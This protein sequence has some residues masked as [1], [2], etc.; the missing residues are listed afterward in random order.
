ML[1]LGS[2]LLL[3]SSP[4]LPIHARQSPTALCSLPPMLGVLTRLSCVVCTQASFSHSPSY[5]L[6]GRSH[7]VA[8]LAGSSNVLDGRTWINLL[9]GRTYWI[10]QATAGLSVDKAALSM[11]ILHLE[12]ALE[13][14]LGLPID[15]VVWVAACI[16][17]IS[18]YFLGSRC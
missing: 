11:I 4:T 16:I 7:L 2:R 9:D 10:W 1:L 6:V 8:E 14:G 18:S 13:F 5:T 15:L 17:M 3:A 12:L